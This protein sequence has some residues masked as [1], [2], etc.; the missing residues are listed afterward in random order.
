MRLIVALSLVVAMGG[1]ALAGPE[2][3]R[4]YTYKGNCTSS[5]GFSDD[6]V[7]NLTSNQNG[8][9]MTLYQ[10]P[11]TSSWVTCT[12]AGTGAGHMDELLS[13]QGGSGQLAQ[14][15]IAKYTGSAGVSWMFI[16]TQADNTGGVVVGADSLFGE[17]PTA[18]TSYWFHILRTTTSQWQYCIENNNT[19][20]EVC[21]YTAAHWAT[22]GFTWYGGETANPNDTMGAHP[23]AITFRTYAMR[24]HTAAGWTAYF[25]DSYLI[26]NCIQG[27]TNR[28]SINCN[29]QDVGSLPGI[30][31]WNQ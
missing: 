13:I 10:I 5:A 8:A 28:F 21:W 20:H 23:E 3:A 17:H 2:S 18:G 7:Q 19:L 9:E 22:A 31:I 25:T 1:V 26:S 16:Y 24:T 14:I 27:G 11:G 15:G 30:F 12:Y 29:I 6:I 4:A